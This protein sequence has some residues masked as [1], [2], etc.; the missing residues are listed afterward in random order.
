M[1]EEIWKDVK[2]YEG[3]YEISNKGNVK[4]L[5]F[6]RTGKHHVLK[7]KHN[8]LGNGIQ[9]KVPNNLINLNLKIRFF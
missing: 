2:G 9:Q 4:S 7:L 1:I 6:R 5:D 8:F 3:Y